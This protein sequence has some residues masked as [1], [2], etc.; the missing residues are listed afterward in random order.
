MT[1][2]NRFGRLGS[3]LTV[4]EVLN[5]WLKARLVLQPIRYL[6]LV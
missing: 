4:M 1:K 6:V 3:K 5:Y 2:I